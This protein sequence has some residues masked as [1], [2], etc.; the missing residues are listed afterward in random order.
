MRNEKERESEREMKKEREK[1]DAGYGFCP[2]RDIIC[3]DSCAWF[4]A[5]KNERYSG[6]ALERIARAINGLRWDH[7]SAK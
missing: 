7:R 1:G 2:I 3:D 5:E 6:C 4:V